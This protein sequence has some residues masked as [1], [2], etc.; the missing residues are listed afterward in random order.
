[1]SLI[2]DALKR[3][4]QAQ[5]E[6]TPPPAPNLQLRPIEPAQYTRRGMGLM[7]PAAL[8]L[9]ALVLLVLLWQRTHS[10]SPAEPTEVHARMAV[11]A[12]P[13]PA[14]Q[15]APVPVA[16]PP[17]V[18]PV[19]EA[20]PAPSTTPTTGPSE[21]VETAAVLL[22]DDPPAVAGSDNRVTNTP[23]ITEAPPPKPSLPKLQAIVFN[24]TRPSVM[25]NGR[26]LFIGDKLNG[27]RV[28]A[29]DKESVTLTGAGQTNVLT[30]PE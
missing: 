10:T 21:V 2:S 18:Q 22:P 9:A 15:A 28:T 19:P 6:T 29:I 25:V 7:P 4:K 20:P 3:A 14:P 5:Q 26:T 8:V 12:T 27:Q 16:P 30:L 13:A 23:A 1:M 24:P 17:A 11:P